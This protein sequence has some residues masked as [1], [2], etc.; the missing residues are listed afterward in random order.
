ML[1]GLL[2]ISCLTKLDC[3]VVNPGR[4]ERQYPYYHNTSNESPIRKVDSVNYSR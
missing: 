2:F 4:P 1:V 3:T